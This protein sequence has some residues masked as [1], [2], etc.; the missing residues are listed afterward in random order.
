LHPCSFQR[1]R[2]AEAVKIAG[3]NA[4]AELLKRGEKLVLVIDE[5]LQVAEEER[6]EQLALWDE[7]GGERAGEIGVGEEGEAFVD[8][9][10][11]EGDASGGF[12][13][14]AGVVD[15]KIAERGEVGQARGLG[16]G[17]DGAESGVALEEVSE[18]CGER[19][20]GSGR[21]P[22]EAIGGNERDE[23]EG[24]VDLLVD[25]GLQSIEEWIRHQRQ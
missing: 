1:A 6:E 9:R 24:F 19:P 3:G 10:A 8:A 14:R 15:R 21:S 13:G 25:F 4:E 20:G 23:V 7:G 5:M 11:I 22:A 16:G 17:E 2:A 12:G 18:E